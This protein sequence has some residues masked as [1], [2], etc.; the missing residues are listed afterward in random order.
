MAQ[1][2]GEM[3]IRLLYLVI[4]LLIGVLKTSQVAHRVI[5]EV[6][7]QWL[8]Q[9]SART[10]TGYYEG[11]QRGT[12]RAEARMGMLLGNCQNQLDYAQEYIAQGCGR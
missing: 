8:T 3:T 5:E 2:G 7:R 10:L 4:G 9:L 11:L 6:D 1:G 12:W